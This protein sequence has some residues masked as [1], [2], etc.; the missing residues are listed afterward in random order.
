MTTLQVKHCEPDRR[1]DGIGP[2]DPMAPVWCNFEPIARSQKA[3]VRFVSEAWACGARE[4][5]YP[6]SFVL[7]VPETWRACLSLRHDPLNAKP[8]AGQKRI[9]AFCGAG[10]G[11]WREEVHGP[12]GGS[13]PRGL[14]AGRQWEPLFDD[15]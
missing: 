14:S 2:I 10:I 15:G 1:Y 9:D 8:W 13:M 12:W 5:Q 11:K 7:V 3:S 4:Q 6:F